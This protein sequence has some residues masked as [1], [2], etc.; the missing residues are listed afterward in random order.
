MA[1]LGRKGTGA[2]ARH[3]AD[4][5]GVCSMLP[6]Q[7]VYILQRFDVGGIANAGT[8]YLNRTEAAAV[9]KVVTRFLQNGMS[10]AQI[11]VITPYEGQRAHVVSVMV[12]N[13]T[14]RQ[15][16]YKEIEVR[17]IWSC[18]ACACGA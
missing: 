3:A 5:S 2:E 18:A 12:R 1:G 6:G 16:L 8:S 4:A 10:P 11:G 13:G 17:A 15:D 9:E 14:A 7:Q